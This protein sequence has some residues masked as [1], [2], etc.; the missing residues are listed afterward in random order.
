MGDKMVEHCDKSCGECEFVD[1]GYDEYSHE[2]FWISERCPLHELMQLYRKVNHYTAPVEW[3]TSYL[4][5]VH[6]KLDEK[7]QHR[8][9]EIDQTLKERHEKN[10]KVGNW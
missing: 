8:N 1:R 9:D 5:C 4:G 10:R 2:V 3:V 7:Y 6:F